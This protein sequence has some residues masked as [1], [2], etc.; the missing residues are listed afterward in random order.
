MEVPITDQKGIFLFRIFQEALNNILKHSLASV[1]QVDLKYLEDEF[2]LEIS[3]NGIGFDMYNKGKFGQFGK[4][5]RI[6]KSL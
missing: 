2:I 4:R 5:G 3:D 6:E 1:I